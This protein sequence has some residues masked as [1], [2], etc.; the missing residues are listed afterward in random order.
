M[1]SKSSQDLATGLLFIAVG[2]AALLIGADYPLGTAQRPGTGVL[3][4][5]LSWCLIG[6]GALVCLK[7]LVTPGP[8]LGAVAWRPALMIT[9]AVIAFALMIDRL[10]LALTMLAA[11][12][13]TALGTPETRWREYA[14][15]AAIM[16]AIGIGVFRYG[17]GMPISV[18][19]RDLA[20]TLPWGLPW[21]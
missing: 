12:T 8:G 11:M 1:R 18:L 2:V 10:G 20:G 13:L 21:R 5:I 17:L 14:L 19:P 9:L 6:T 16:L 4:R 3:P 15:F 7:A